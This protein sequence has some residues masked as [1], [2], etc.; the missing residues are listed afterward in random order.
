MLEFML[1]APAPV[2]EGV[3]SGLLPPRWRFRRRPGEG[4]PFARCRSSSEQ[5]GAHHSDL[6]DLDRERRSQ[7]LDGKLSGCR[8][9]PDHLA[10]NQPAAFDLGA[11]DRH[12]NW[13]AVEVVTVVIG[14]Q[15]PVGG[16]VES[17]ALLAAGEQHCQ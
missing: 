13:H 16:P 4:L 5:A 17:A 1:H 11:F 2:R 14:N 15:N 6:Y 8:R 10:S 9:V 12:G 7:E 3:G